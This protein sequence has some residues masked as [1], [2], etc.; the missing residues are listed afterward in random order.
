MP[1]R[2][3]SAFFF[4]VCQ[5]LLRLPCSNSITAHNVH[6]CRSKLHYGSSRLFF[7]ATNEGN[8]QRESASTTGGDPIREST[9]I[10]PSLHPVTINAIAQALKIRSKNLSDMPLRVSATGVEP[11][12]VALTAGKVALEA[13][14]K[15]QATSDKDGMKL[16]PEEEQTIAGRVVGVV[17]RFEELEAKL[18]QKCNSAGWIS[19]YDEWSSFGI[20]QQ[21]NASVVD[22]EILRDSLFA[23]NRAECLLALFLSLVEN[24]NLE[25]RSETVPGGSDVNFLDT[26]RKNVLLGHQ[27]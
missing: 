20:L 22:D 2:S 18:V 24:P 13:I 8:G 25:Q 6:S 21:E 14:K 12:Q 15:R 3:Q 10:R 9:G 1:I 16:Y 4:L 11:L 23:M 5:I 17:M 26:D 19:K 27:Q 7:S